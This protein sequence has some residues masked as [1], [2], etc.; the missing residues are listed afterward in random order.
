MRRGPS[1]IS[2]R[3]SFIVRSILSDIINC[4]NSDEEDESEAM[5]SSHDEKEIDVCW[6]SFTQF[7]VSRDLPDTLI[8]LIVS[9]A[10][11]KTDEA[12]RSSHEQKN[13]DYRSLDFNHQ[14]TPQSSYSQHL[15]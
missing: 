14:P 9:P 15:A 7:T 13:K 6:T 1:L 12:L 2:R 10:A 8:T 5:S 11:G 3:P 4:F